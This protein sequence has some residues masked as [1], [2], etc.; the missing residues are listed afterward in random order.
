MDIE[1]FT[2][3]TH[4]IRVH[5]ADCG[6][7]IAGDDKYGNSECNRALKKLGLK[8]LFLHAYRLEFT[9]PGTNKD[10]DIIAPLPDDLG[11]VLDSLAQIRKGR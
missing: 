10:I 8:R 2:G 6:H 7:P 9:H 11:D 3:R 4:Q 1:L 5:A